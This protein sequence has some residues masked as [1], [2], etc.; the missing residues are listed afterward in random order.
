[1]LKQGEINLSDDTKGNTASEM[2][3]EAIEKEVKELAEKQKPKQTDFE[4]YTENFDDK[5]DTYDDDIETVE[6]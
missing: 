1:M 5:S 6:F 3:P 4:K 2:S